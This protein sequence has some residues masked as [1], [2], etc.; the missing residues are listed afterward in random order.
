M[1]PA[2][3]ELPAALLVIA[4]GAMACLAGYRLF[5]VVLAVYGFVLG[6]VIASSIVGVTN[7]VGMIV[8]ALGGG[9]IGAL[10]LVFAYFA[11]I[12][13]VGGA[14]GALLTHALWSQLGSGEPPAFL[15][16]GASVAGAIAAM[17]LQRYVIIV[18]TAFGGAWTTI[19]GLMSIV[20]GRAARPAGTDPVWIL[21]P[22]LPADSRLSL[23]AWIALGLAGTAI[24]LAIT[25]RTMNGRARRS[26]T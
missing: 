19:V 15:I 10:T 14:L 1:L 5:R 11:G 9:V 18:G 17:F 4:G 25:G 13:L 6:A 2:A 8:A 26:K 24:Q 3:Y 20:Q 22:T 21:Y 16:V 23:L 7:T 12:A